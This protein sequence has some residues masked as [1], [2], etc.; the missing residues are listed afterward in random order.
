MNNNNITGIILA[1]GR[2]S[3]MKSE[4][5]LVK[6]RKKLLIEYPVNIFKEICSDIIISSNHNKF[7]FLDCKVYH[8]EIIDCGPIGGIYTCLKKS[9]TDYNLIAA[10]DMPFLNNE[11]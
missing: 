9:I 7:N 5:G 2:S 1:G 11:L 8:D 4:K 3:R 6:F 10:C